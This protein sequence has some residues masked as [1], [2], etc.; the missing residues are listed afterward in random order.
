MNYRRT[1]GRS[2]NGKIDQRTT[3]IGHYRSP[4][5]RTIVG[6]KHIVEQTAPV[7]DHWGTTT[8]NGCAMYIIVAHTICEESDTAAVRSPAG[9][10]SK[11]SNT[12]IS[13]D[14][15]LRL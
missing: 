11:P 6:H 2:I 7:V 5:C 1:T 15:S 10:I 8:G 12:V 14:T 3:L 13:T 4:L 9:S